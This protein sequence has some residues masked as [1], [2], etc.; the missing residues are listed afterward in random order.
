MTKTQLKKLDRIIAQIERLQ[1][2]VPGNS[3]LRD[4]KEELLRLWN[5]QHRAAAE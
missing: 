3:R 5:E 4:A 2:A 1:D